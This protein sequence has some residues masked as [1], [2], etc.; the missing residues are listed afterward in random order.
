M[1]SLRSELILGDAEVL[2]LLFLGKWRLP[3]LQEL[4]DGPRRLSQLK[5]AIPGATKKML[6]DTLHALEALRWI[7][8]CEYHYR[9]KRVDYSVAEGIAGNYAG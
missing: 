9:I 7:V 5:R 1:D 3:V 6:I 4:L 8:R 2:R